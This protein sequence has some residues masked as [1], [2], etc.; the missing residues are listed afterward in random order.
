MAQIYLSLWA[1]EPLIVTRLFNSN[2][3][4]KN[5]NGYKIRSLSFLYAI[6]SI[7]QKSLN[8]T[9]KCVPPPCH[10]G[11]LSSGAHNQLKAKYTFLMSIIL[12]VSLSD[13]PIRRTVSCTDFNQPTCCAGPFLHSLE[14]DLLFP[15]T[16][17]PSYCTAGFH[18]LSLLNKTSQTFRICLNHKAELWHVGHST[19]QAEQVLGKSMTGPWYQ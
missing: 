6:R 12:F 15:S 17:V 8:C 11:T 2:I 19:L 10:I 5:T 7:F 16:Y 14:D 3:I 9:L 4:D 13:Q 1:I 18:G